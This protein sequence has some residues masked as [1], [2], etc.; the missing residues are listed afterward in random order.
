MKMRSREDIYQH[1]IARYKKF[2]QKI[3]KVFD[4]ISYIRGVAAVLAITAFVIGV[5][6]EPQSVYYGLA[7][8]SLAV[9]MVG[10]TIHKRLSGRI[11]QINSLLAI[12][13]EGL[14]R[15]RDQWA[16]FRITGEEFL[17]DSM[18]HL[19][20]LNILGKNSLFQMIQMCSTLRGARTLADWLSSCDDFKVIAQRQEAVKEISPRRSMRQHLLMEG[21]LLGRPLD[22]NRF[23]EWI[24]TPSLLS[25][26]PWLV[27]LQR[28]LVS[29]TL[30]LML[31]DVFIEIRPYWILGLLIQAVVFAMTAG[32]CRHHYAPALSRDSLFLAYGNMFHLLESRQFQSGYLKKLHAMFFIGGKGISLQ[33]KK[34]EK[35]NSALSLCYGSIY[36]FINMLLLW[37][38]HFLYRLEKWKE[39]MTTSIDHCFEALGEIEALSSL[40]GF[41]DD[42]PEY[43]FPHIDPSNVPLSA[44][45]LGHPLIPDHERVA[46]DFEIPAEGFLAL[47]TGSNMS[48]KSTFVRTVGINM[49]LA[50]SGAP[51]TARFLAARPC[52]ILTCIQ[53][54]DSI[55]L[56]V[57]HFYAE[58]KSIK[59]ILDAVTPPDTHPDASPCLY[60][61]DEI[62]S[63]TNTKERLIAS[64]G[65]MLKLAGSSSCGLVTTHDLELVTLENQTDRIKNFHFKDEID[66]NG[67]MVFHYQIHEGPVSS[68]NALELLKREGIKL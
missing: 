45:K 46:N 30:V 7:L 33:M 44:G 18:P 20:D 27:V 57:S 4:R 12:N 10:I 36:P 3:Q 13:Q 29:T 55:R 17:D 65:I 64:R 50:F 14:L 22:P 9:F 32:R 34:L 54:S 48:G 37:D 52:R 53:V 39:S 56:H 67:Q 62:F 41:S 61:I 38:I 68:T 26:R 2:H 35:I 5:Y 11:R 51:V 47:I 63:G 58:V 31:L 24:K 21:R 1:R 42:H 59:K 40:A 25:P 8:V 60:L 19:T 43:A 49:A 66:K 16:D 15:M 23:L 6:V 28:A